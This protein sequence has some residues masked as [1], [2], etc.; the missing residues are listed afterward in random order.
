MSTGVGI[1]PQGHWEACRPESRGTCQYRPAYALR[2]TAGTRDSGPS[3]GTQAPAQHH[4]ANGSRNRNVTIT[5][6]VAPIPPTNY[7]PVTVYF[8][9]TDPD[10]R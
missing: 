6:Y 2:A 7:P 9:V 3:A 8:E 10:D 4:N 1:K 5:A